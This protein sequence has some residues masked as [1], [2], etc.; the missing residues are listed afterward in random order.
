MI[1]KHPDLVAIV[2]AWHAVQTA[3]PPFQA[4]RKADL[5][6]LVAPVMTE[7]SQLVRGLDDSWGLIDEERGRRGFGPADDEPTDPDYT[8]AIDFWVVWL[9]RY[10]AIE[11][12]VKLCGLVVMAPTPIVP[13]VPT[14]PSVQMPQLPGFPTSRVSF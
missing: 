13:D 9:H 5:D 8:Q 2:D 12:V 4:T 11:E 1:E 14:P 10:E 7:R 3:P 6:R